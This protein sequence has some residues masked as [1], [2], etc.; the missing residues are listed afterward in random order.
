MIRTRKIEGIAIILIGF[1]LLYSSLTTGWAEP[2]PIY[3]AILSYYLPLAIGLMSV[4]FGFF[5][6]LKGR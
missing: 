4:G 1:Y 5:L 6:L 2:P 3:E